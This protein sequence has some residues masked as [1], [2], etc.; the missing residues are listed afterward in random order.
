[1]TKEIKQSKRGGPRKGAGRKS[2]AAKVAKMVASGAITEPTPEQQQAEEVLTTALA[3]I[4][5]PT[6][7]KPEYASQVEKLCRLGA[8]EREIADFFGVSTVTIWRWSHRH[9]AFCN[10]L[11]AGKEPADDRVERSL[12]NRAV[13][14]S[15]ESVKIF[16]PAGATEP[17]YAPYTEHVPPDVTAASKWLNNR[18]PDAWRDKQQHEHTGANGAP[19]VPVINVTIGAAESSSAS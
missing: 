12:Y 1:M 17:V 4:G 11:K 13:G 6:E 5:R 16:M 18:R 19:L 3:K 14:Y 9:D 10:A 2:R 15:F 8:T 7:Y